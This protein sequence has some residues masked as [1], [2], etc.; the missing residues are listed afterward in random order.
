MTTA[1]DIAWKWLE[2]EVAW[3]W[4]DKIVTNQNKMQMQG[5]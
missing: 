3:K 1:R 2:V 5:R 4:L